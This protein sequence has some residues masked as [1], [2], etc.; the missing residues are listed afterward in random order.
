MF[1]RYNKELQEL[2]DNFCNRKLI[3]LKKSGKYIFEDNKKYLNLS[4]NDY[5]GIAED[6]KILKNFLKIAD[7]SM[8]SA[9]S[10]LLTGSSY[11]Y[12]KLECLLAALYRKDK[13]LIFNSGYH[14]NTGIM[15]ALLSKR[16]VVFCDKLN[17]ASILDGIK[18]SEAKMFRYKHLDYE[19]LEELLQKNRNEYDTA[20]IVTESLFSMDGDIA[21]LNKLVEIKKKYNAI[22]VVDE[23]RGSVAADGEGGDV[24]VVVRV[25]QTADERDIPDLL[26]AREDVEYL[27]HLGV[28]RSEILVFVLGC[29]A[30]VVEGGVALFGHADQHVEAVFSEDGFPGEGI[31]VDPAAGL[32]AS[33]D[34]L[35]LVEVSAGSRRG[36]E[37]P[38]LERVVVITGRNAQ[39]EV[40]QDV[41][42]EIG[43]EHHAVDPLG[44]FGLVGD[45]DGVSVIAV[46]VGVE[47]GLRDSG[48]AEEGLRGFVEFEG[49]SGE[50]RGDDTGDLG[51]SFA[52]GGD[53]VIDDAVVSDVDAR[54]EEVGETVVDGGLRGEFLPVGG[55]QHRLVL[56]VG[57]GEE[58]AGLVAGV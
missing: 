58:H 21:D 35:S 27:G 11:V 33:D 34:A 32:G 51:G 44:E 26:L 20:I 55:D 39:G 24:S 41:G 23:A 14:A 31:F 50:R 40:L 3:S 53:A 38:V 30:A 19:H 56:H 47:R 28:V 4:S 1:E 54:A 8:G 18:L 2:K 9:S 48:T 13:A 29:F 6:R 12:A 15:S 36:V 45:V 16:D 57:S 42:F 46:D 25:V 49:Q 22:L 10:R 17:H 7:F 43:V 37:L 52:A 5:L